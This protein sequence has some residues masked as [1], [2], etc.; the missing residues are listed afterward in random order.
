MDASERESLA[1]ALTSKAQELIDAATDVAV[2]MRP[3]DDGGGVFMGDTA[4]HKAEERTKRLREI[5]QSI[6]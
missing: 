2:E 1:Q 3:S 6:P 5:I 4:A